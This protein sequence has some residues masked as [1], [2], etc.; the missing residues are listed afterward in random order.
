M[1]TKEF[2]EPVFIVGTEN[3]LN[4]DEL[5]ELVLG[6]K[7]RYITVDNSTRGVSVATIQKGSQ[8]SLNEAI[9]I[10]PVL[11]KK[12]FRQIVKELET[13]KSGK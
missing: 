12:Q 6:A 8:A 5:T 3:K 4:T 1:A 13:L 7:L 9:K 2:L 10:S 11:S